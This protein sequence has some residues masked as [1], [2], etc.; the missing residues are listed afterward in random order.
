MIGILTPSVVLAILLIAAG[1]S[2][3]NYSA[4]VVVGGIAM[5]LG[6]AAPLIHLAGFV[7]GVLGWRSRYPKKL[8]SVV[9]SVLNAI[10]TITS[11]LGWIYAILSIWRGAGHSA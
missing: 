4:A 2:L 10:L 7:F 3:I 5:S 9:G 8:V 1:V 11:V 6:M